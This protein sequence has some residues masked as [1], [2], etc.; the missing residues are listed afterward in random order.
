MVKRNGKYVRSWNASREHK[1]VEFTR[2]YCREHGIRYQ[3]KGP[4]DA[5]YIYNVNLHKYVQVCYCLLNLSEQ[6]IV[7]MIE[8]AIL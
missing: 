2:E 5:L 7:N 4:N 3:I 8:T 6:D 1:K